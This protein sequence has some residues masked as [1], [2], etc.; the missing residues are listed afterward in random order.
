M[1]TNANQTQNTQLNVNA[2]LFL[3]MPNLL[4][5][6]LYH[7]HGTAHFQLCLLLNFLGYNGCIT[8]K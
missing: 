2:N 4:L 1:A 6:I 7:K 3:V 8:R 5:K